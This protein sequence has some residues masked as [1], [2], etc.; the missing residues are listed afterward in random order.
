FA[1]SVSGGTVRRLHAQAN[2][3]LSLPITTTT[4]PGDVGVSGA[5]SFGMRPLV[6]TPELQVAARGSCNRFL[7]STPERS[8]RKVLTGGL[9]V[10]FTPDQDSDQKW[11]LVIGAGVART[12]KRFTQVTDPYGCLGAGAEIGSE[13]KPRLIVELRLTDISN[14]TYGDFRYLT[15]SV[16]I[17][18]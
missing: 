16:G 15:L 12:D 9:D 3:G 10:L 1:A 4:D 8:V 18:F 17:K 14:S 5:L 13:D 11:Y 2:G 6:S 7:S